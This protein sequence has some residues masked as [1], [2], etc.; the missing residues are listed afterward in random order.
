MVL[1]ERR[2]R[3]NPQKVQWLCP[4]QV[5]NRC[6]NILLPIIMCN[7]FPPSPS[8]HPFPDPPHPHLPQ[9]QLPS[10]SPPIHCTTPPP[11]PISS[12]PSHSYPPPTPFATPS[13][14]LA[15]PLTFLLLLPPSLPSFLHPPHFHSLFHPLLPF[16]LYTNPPHLFHPSSPLLN[17][18]PLPVPPP[19]RP[20]PSR[21]CFHY[22]L[23]LPQGWALETQ[24]CVP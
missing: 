7:F 1:E 17:P 12:S 15:T 9:H 10:L 16:S 6:L 8:S 23:L 22:I 4:K 14:P 5:A 19:P 20:T 13:I 2:S 21:L 18:P 11:S 24:T 3:A